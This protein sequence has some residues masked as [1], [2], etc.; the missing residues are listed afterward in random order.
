MNTGSPKS[1]RLTVGM[2]ILSWRG[3]ASL[4]HALSTYDKAGLY[5]LFDE[6]AI[7]LP[8]PDEAVKSAAS[9]HPLNVREFPQNLGIAGG[10]QA[11]AESLSTDYILF[12]EN[13][14]P[15]I[16]PIDEVKAQLALS[17]KAL[18]ANDCRMVRL[19]SRTN[20]GELFNA[21]PKYKRYW[22]NNISAKLRRTLRPSKARRLCGT[23]VYDGLNPHERHPNFIKKYS[24]NSYIV[25]PRVMP[26]TNQSILMKRRD[27]LD[28]ILPYVNAQPLTRAINGFHNV[29]IELN[30]STFWTESNF[31]ILCP[32]G[33]FTH[34]RLN[35]R[36][37]E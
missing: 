37:Y 28:V 8:E 2:G 22:D 9:A 23:A 4:E 10:M 6:R 5:E 19:R 34:K 16:E 7:I 35:D 11:V 20:P 30:R 33:L 14:C 21:L 26:W 36:G 12:L 32:K 1:T 17:L 18:E 13:D 29:E 24:A 25:S 15:L 27:F 3:A 31:N